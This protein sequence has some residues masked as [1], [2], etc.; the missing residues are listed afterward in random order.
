MSKGNADGQ[1]Q[2]RPIAT[3]EPMQKRRAHEKLT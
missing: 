2:N 3:N 1:L